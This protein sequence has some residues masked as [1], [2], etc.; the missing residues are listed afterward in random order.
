M[1]KTSQS[2]GKYILCNKSY[3]KDKEGG[4]TM[5]N[6]IKQLLLEISKLD[7]KNKP[8]NK[9]HNSLDWLENLTFEDVC[10][11]ELFVPFE[12]IKISLDK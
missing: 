4:E 2:L 11:K 10:D 9:S 12:E 3:S 7:K 8:I 6:D 5:K 1:S